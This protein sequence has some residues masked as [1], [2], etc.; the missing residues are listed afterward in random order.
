MTK[1]GDSGWSLSAFSEMLDQQGKEQAEREERELAYMREQMPRI[2]AEIDGMS[3]A[4]LVQY[5]E[6]TVWKTGGYDPRFQALW[7]EVL[8]HVKTQ[9]LGRLG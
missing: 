4:D 2:K 7:T 9:L 1:H 8:D 3:A 5:F 6:H